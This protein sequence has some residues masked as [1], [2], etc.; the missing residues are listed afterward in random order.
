MRFEIGRQ[1]F[2][3]MLTTVTGSLPS[4]TTYPVLQNMMVEVSSGKMAL[5]GTDLDTFVRKSAEVTK[6][7]DGRA[8]V[9][10]RKLLEI[11]RELAGESVLVYSKNNNMHVEGGG[12]RSYFAGLDAAEYP[13]LPKVPEGPTLEFAMA[14]VFELLDDTSFAISKD[15]SR[16]AMS[17]VNWEV[18]KTA[19]KMVATDGHRLA[20]VSRKGKF[21]A[22]LKVVLSPKVLALLPREGENVTVHSDPGR[23]AFVCKDT[24]VIGRPIDG[25]FPD[26]ERVLPKK[27]YPSRAVLSREDFGAILR[28]ASVFAHPVGR[29]VAFEFNKEQVRVHAE[30]PELGC[31]DEEVSCQYTGDPVR[32]GFNAAYL[33]EILRHIRS[34]Q[35]A[36]ELQ[37]PVSAGLVKPFDKQTEYEQTFLLMPIR[38][39]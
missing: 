4:R 14:S 32:I 5:S 2:V 28:R 39:D 38:L 36:V 12:A 29:L 19:M 6:S 7:E 15:E 22:T 9:P 26:Y 20:Y 31:F 34:E 21:P 8:V 3:D 10:G 35:V 25:P 23:I 11:A 18:G 30:T 17:G 37:S 24:L 27:D 13:E 1:N 33:A 16:P